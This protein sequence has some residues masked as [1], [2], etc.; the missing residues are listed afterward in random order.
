MGN[1]RDRSLWWRNPYLLLLALGLAAPLF[2]EIAPWFTPDVMLLHGSI[3][4]LAMMDVNL[5]VAAMGSA[6]LYFCLLPHSRAELLFVVAGGVC[7]DAWLISERL[8]YIGAY[9]QLLHIGLGFYPF[10]L[11]ALLW[12]LAASW[13]GSGEDTLRL[14]EVLGLCLAMPVLYACGG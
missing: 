3:P 7:A 2:F 4:M 11:A 8:N 6:V 12:R 13:R 10:V 5:A 14:A 1:C 9:G